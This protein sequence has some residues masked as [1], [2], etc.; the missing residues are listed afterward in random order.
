MA[1]LVISFGQGGLNNTG[2]MVRLFDGA[3]TVV[4]VVGSDRRGVVLRRSNLWRFELKKFY[5]KN[6]SDESRK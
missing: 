5:G 2:E 1:D 6:R 3:G 4:D